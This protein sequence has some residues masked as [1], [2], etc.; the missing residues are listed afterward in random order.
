M[1]FPVGLDPEHIHSGR[2]QMRSALIHTTVA[3]LAI[4]V[5]VAPAHARPDSP[6]TMAEAVDLALAAEPGQMA[7]EARAAALDER[8][9][10]AGELPD[11]RLRLG[12]QQLPTGIRWLFHRGHD[13]GHRRLSPGV[14]G[15]QD[16]ILVLREVRPA[17]RPDERKRQ[18]PRA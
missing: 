11:P 16:T 4:M 1:F 12:H 6:L 13:S 17:L 9:V 2:R 3:V 7:L 10:V 18:C 15:W 5:I 14:P 8:A